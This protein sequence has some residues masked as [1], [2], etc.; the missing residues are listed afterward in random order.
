MS[1]LI[2]LISLIRDAAITSFAISIVSG[3]SRSVVFIPFL[4]ISIA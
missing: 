1:A 4:A 2:R 3:L